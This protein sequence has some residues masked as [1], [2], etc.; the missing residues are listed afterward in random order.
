ME[1]TQIVFLAITVS[2]VYFMIMIGSIIYMRPDYFIKKSTERKGLKQHNLT[3][4]IGKIIKNLIGVILMIV[5][6]LMLFLPGQGLLTILL[7]LFFVDFPG[8]RKL[9]LRL[10]R[11]PA[12]YKTINNVRAIAKQPPII[13]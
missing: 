4:Y 9:E 7:G 13:L 8:K 3:W 1:P 12:I 2:I 11:K 10:I 6:V 5:G